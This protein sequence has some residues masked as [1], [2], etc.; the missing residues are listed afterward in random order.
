MYVLY[1]Y[2][3]ILQRVQ[4]PLNIKSAIFLS[5]INFL[6]CLGGN[7]E[8]LFTGIVFILSLTIISSSRLSTWVCNSQHTL[9]KLNYKYIIHKKGDTATQITSANQEQIFIR[10]KESYYLPFVW[11]ATKMDLL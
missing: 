4:Q 7:W 10:F 1:F 3:N 2:L 9:Q 11:L 8:I 5:M 6:T